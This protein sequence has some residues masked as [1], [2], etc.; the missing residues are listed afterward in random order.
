MVSGSWPLRRSR[1]TVRACPGNSSLSVKMVRLRSPSRQPVET[2]SSAR[3]RE[4][5]PLTKAA[6]ESSGGGV[7]PTDVDAAEISEARAA[8]A[9]ATKT[10]PGSAARGWDACAGSYAKFE[11]G[12]AARR[13]E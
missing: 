1:R 10:R 4:S 8:V 11:T 5:A 7:S 9:A 6:Q 2:G 3:A 13:A 12:H